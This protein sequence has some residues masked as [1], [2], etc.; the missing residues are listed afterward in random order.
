M[1]ARALQKIGAGIQIQP[2]A[3]RI[4]RRW[5]LSSALAERS[6]TPRDILIRSWRDGKILSRQNLVPFTERVYD[7]PFWVLHRADLHGV[8]WREARR[9][10]V[11]VTLGKRVVKVQPE[12][13]RCGLSQV[14]DSG[15]MWCLDAM[16]RGRLVEMLC[17]REFQEWPMLVVTRS[18]GSS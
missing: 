2:N 7:A 13:L 1:T 8:L 11:P 4:L 5:G 9:L 6:A 12:G 16:G 10:D 17:R 3:A 15:R 14:R 18:F